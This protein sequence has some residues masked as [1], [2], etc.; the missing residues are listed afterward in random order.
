[1]S[2]V[3]PIE[4]T[5]LMAAQLDVRTE[6]ARTFSLTSSML[7]QSWNFTHLVNWMHTERASLILQQPA[8][9]AIGVEMVITW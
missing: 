1:M 8:L 5:G 4:L 2:H 3:R 6:L 7:F 9:N